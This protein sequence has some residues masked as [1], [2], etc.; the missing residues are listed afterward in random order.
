MTREHY[1]SRGIFLSKMVH[2]RGPLP[3]RMPAGEQS[4]E[5]LVVR[6]LC[7][8]HNETLSDLDQS[9]IDLINAFRE[10][11]G[12]R[13]LRKDSSRTW[14]DDPPLT[15]DGPRLQR[16]CLKMVMTNTI[17]QREHLRGWQPPDWLPQVIFGERS[18]P[19][20]CGL[21]M[22]VRIN[23]QI[24]AGENISF[25]FGRSNDEIPTCALLE[26][27]HGWLFFLTWDK[28]LTPDGYVNL[29]G[30]RYDR[31]DILHPPR[32]ITFSNSPTQPI[33]VSI[34]FDWSG[35]WSASRNRNVARLRTKYMA[36]ARPG[37]KKRRSG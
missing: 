23:D 3:S 31:G 16:C 25:A 10:V 1:F 8:K 26:L 24:A 22:L 21:S 34:A 6:C 30:H 28:P 27:R 37:S 15:L 29:M 11:E 9:L 17:F 19:E 4:I 35:T 12:L 7:K 20:G 33:G 36:P 2:L 18:L 5:N 14:P 13:A 32:Q